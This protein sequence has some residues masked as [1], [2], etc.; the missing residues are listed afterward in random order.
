MRETNHKQKT[1]FFYYYLLATFFR[2][3][4]GQNL[5]RYGRVQR[6]EHRS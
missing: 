6:Q 1:N 3:Q 2:N 5:M 4:M